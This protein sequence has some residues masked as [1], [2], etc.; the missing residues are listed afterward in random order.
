[1]AGGIGV[2]LEVLVLLGV[3]RALE[4]LGPQRHDVL[5]GGVDVGAGVAE[6]TEQGVVVRRL[7]FEVAPQLG[8]GRAAAV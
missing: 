4:Q 7:G 1:M 2:H 8:R 3:L 5:V 6:L